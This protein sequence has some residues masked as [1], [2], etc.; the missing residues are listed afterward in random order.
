MVI[1][2]YIEFPECNP[3]VSRG[4]LYSVVNGIR[5]LSHSNY[6]EGIA[7][8][9]VKTNLKYQGTRCFTCLIYPDEF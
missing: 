9:A 5:F 6:F 3:Y 8:S 1:L 2:T 4:A 7:I